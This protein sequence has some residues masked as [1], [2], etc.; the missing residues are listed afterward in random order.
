MVRFGVDLQEGLRRLEELRA[1]AVPP[2]G[3]SYRGG[4]AHHPSR[5]RCGGKPVAS[6]RPGVERDSLR[7]VILE[8]GQPTQT[9]LAAV[10]AQ[11]S[12]RHDGHLDRGSRRRAVLLHVDHRLRRCSEICWGCW[13]KVRTQDRSTKRLVQVAASISRC[14]PVWW[15]ALLLR[16]SLVGS[17]R[18]AVLARDEPVPPRPRRLRL[19]SRLSQGSTVPV[20]PL[21]DS[22]SEEGATLTMFGQQPWRMSVVR[23]R[24]S[25][26]RWAISLM[27]MVILRWG[28]WNT[29]L[30]RQHLRGWMHLICDVITRRG[31]VLKSPP[32]LQE[33]ERSRAEVDNNRSVRVWK[34]SSLASIVVVPF[35]S[36]GHRRRNCRIDFLSSRG[37]V[38]VVAVEPGC[39]RVSRPFGYMEG[40]SAHFCRHFCILVRRG[41][42]CCAGDGQHGRLP[43]G[44]S[45]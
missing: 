44:G 35:L 12:F 39:G 16:R 19:T 8:E 38:A 18:F 13:S 41:I 31:R 1:A 45:N 20:F 28:I 21:E 24:H 17:G 7:A 10:P 14:P 5:F 42:T 15:F 25:P 2:C 33:A 29:L 6:S 9:V 32:A 43:M 3:A 4:A 27:R 23:H 36:W 30:R 11:E 34:L 26:E 37:V 22:D 40:R